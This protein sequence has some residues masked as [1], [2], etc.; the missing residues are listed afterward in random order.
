MDRIRRE[1]GKQHD[2]SAAAIERAA[3]RKGL[4]VAAT[5]QTAPTAAGEEHGL[6]EKSNRSFCAGG[7][8]GEGINAQRRGFKALLIRRV[9]FDLIGLPPAPAEVDDFVADSS[10]A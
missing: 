9:Y 6:G 5:G 3:R 1:V 2:R 10:G 8:G 7:A 4:V